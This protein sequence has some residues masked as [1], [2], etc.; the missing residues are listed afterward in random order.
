MP[1]QTVSIPLEETTPFIRQ[2]RNGMVTAK[3]AHRRAHGTSGSA[4]AATS[5]Y[6]VR[7]IMC[8]PHLSP[9]ISSSATN[10]Q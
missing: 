9:S 3:V 1:M 10:I 5:Q 8:V 2:T 4:Q 7:P 6:M